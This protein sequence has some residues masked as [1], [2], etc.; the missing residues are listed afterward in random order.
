MLRRR[1]LLND[2]SVKP[3]EAR[4]LNEPLNETDYH[5]DSQS[6]DLDQPPKASIAITRNQ[7]Q[8]L[9][10]VDAEIVREPGKQPSRFVDRLSNSHVLP[11]SATGFEILQANLGKMC[12]MTCAHYHVDT[13]PDRR[14]I[15]A[16]QKKSIKI[17]F[18]SKQ[19]IVATS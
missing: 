16:F 12:N 1:L 7:L 9:D 11:L 2:S 3:C 8:V 19:S 13:R 14:E 5:E 6:K 15:I 10:N 17:D 18:L 4:S